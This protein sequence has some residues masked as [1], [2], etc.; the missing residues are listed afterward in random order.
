MTSKTYPLYIKFL[1][2]NKDMNRYE[3][4]VKQITEKYGINYDLIQ[5]SHYTEDN[6]EEYESFMKILVPTS[7]QKN[8]E[9]HYLLVKEIFESFAEFHPSY[10]EEPTNLTIRK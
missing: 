9:Q 7:N 1:V 4:K 5:F 8:S 10:S 2:R 6:L 3:I